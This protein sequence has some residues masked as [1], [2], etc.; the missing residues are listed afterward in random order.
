MRKYI[1]FHKKRVISF[2]FSKLTGEGDSRKYAQTDEAESDR[3]RD[4]RFRKRGKRARL[5]K[6]LLK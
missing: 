6:S 1:D 3:A 5:K 4:D 2:P